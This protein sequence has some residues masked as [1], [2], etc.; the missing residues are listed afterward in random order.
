MVTKYGIELRKIRVVR[1]ETLQDMADKVEFSIS[2]LSSI[3]NGIRKIPKNLT[4]KIIKVYDDLTEEEIR[5]LKA[6]E[7]ESKE[8]VSIGLLNLNEKQKKL[9][10]SLSRKHQVWMMKQS[11]ITE[12][13]DKEKRMAKKEYYA[14]PHSIEK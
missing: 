4:K 8:E 6:A 2:Y 14:S 1:R 9:A 5:T 12:I 10:M 11:K 3:E 13:I 7:L